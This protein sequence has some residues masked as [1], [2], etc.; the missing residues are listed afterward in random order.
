VTRELSLPKVASGTIWA[1][2]GRLNIAIPK[3]SILKALVASSKLP[4][5][6]PT[7]QILFTLI[8]FAKAK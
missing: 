8:L 6:F 7:P 5:Q 2:A 3:G 1:K 4:L